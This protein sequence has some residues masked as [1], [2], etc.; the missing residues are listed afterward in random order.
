M[1]KKE[2]KR[3]EEYLSAQSEILNESL[4][5]WQLKTL[6]QVKWVEGMENEP[7][8]TFSFF[9][10]DDDDDDDEEFFGHPLHHAPD[11][12]KQQASEELNYCV[13]KLQWEQT[14]MNNLD[15]RIQDFL[16]LKNK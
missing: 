10:D 13:S 5:F 2:I 7:K 4:D 8:E 12:L 9:D 15:S 11:S 6:E 1:T 14:Q 3:Q 16:R